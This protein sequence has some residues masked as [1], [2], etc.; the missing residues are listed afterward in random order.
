MTSLKKA[1]VLYVDHQG[2]PAPLTE[3]FHATASRRLSSTLQRFPPSSVTSIDSAYCPNCLTSQDPVQY[4]NRCQRCPVCVHAML[5]IMVRDNHCVYECA[6]CQWRSAISVPVV[7]NASK[8][9][10]ARAAEDLCLQ[11]KEARQVADHKD[12]FSERKIRREIHS[13]RSFE[14]EKDWSLE[15]L[16]A[17]L[18]TKR[19][20]K[21]SF[22][23]ESS[24]VE[25]SLSIQRL[26]LED[27]ED[28]RFEGTIG[29]WQWQA[30][31]RGVHRNDLLPLPVP[32]RARRSRRCRAEL[33][34]G[35]P[36]ILVKPKV[37][38]LEGDSS[39]RTGHG[40]WWRKDSSAIH[41][42]PRVRV[43]KMV[44]QE[45]SIH[46]LLQV[47]NPTLGLIRLRW[48]PSPYCGE[49]DWDG[50]VTL[51]LPHLL[52]DTIT[53][54]IW[55]VRLLEAEERQF[56][57]TEIIELASAEDSLL[58]LSH[59]SGNQVPEAVSRWSGTSE[60]TQWIAQQQQDAW[61]EVVVKIKAAMK[62]N[63]HWAIPLRMQVELG[64][65]SWE[66]SLIQ[67]D[68]SKETDW[69]DFDVVLTWES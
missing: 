37:N 18:E 13:L 53:Q 10:I 62:N 38:P 34:S 48:S 59:S 23:E 33:A 11:A 50:N 35:R 51:L 54:E 55:H 8:V 32:L 49:E 66:S 65:G 5:Q 64:N 29:A 25:S 27:E 26:D 28:T 69:V 15:I 30:L 17:T 57:T 46:F 9:E 45:Q 52:V 20:Q 67:Q 6:T 21:S 42:I 2:H 1:Y 63:E 12:L 3:C 58:E 22:P 7:E 16:E 47:T 44:Y 60:H 4:C 19:K 61:L 39:L 43:M 56:E 14:R 68:T 31:V 41:V 36:G 24:K 40:Q